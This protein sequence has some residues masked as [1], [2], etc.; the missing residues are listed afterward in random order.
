MAERTRKRQEKSSLKARQKQEKEEAKLQKQREKEQAKALQESVEGSKEAANR[1]S[2]M[3]RI[4]QR[5]CEV[6]KKH[7]RKWMEKRRELLGD[8]P[9]GENE[10]E[11]PTSD[12]TVRG[13]ATGCK[14]RKKKFGEM[15][16]R[17]LDKTEA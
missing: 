7:E 3:R 17:L 1:D 15:L 13:A 11:L 2:E 8:T 4:A 10:W 5:N 14:V 9:V 6:R 16:R 12:G